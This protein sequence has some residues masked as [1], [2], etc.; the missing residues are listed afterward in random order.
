[1]K[2]DYYEIRNIYNNEINVN[3]KNK[4]RI[5]NFEKKKEMY[6]LR[7]YDELSKVTYNGGKYN[8]F[9]VYKPKIRVIMSQSVYDKTINHYV[10]RTILEPKLTKY[11]SDKNVATRKD[12]GT[13]RGILLLKKYIEE[14]KKYGKFYFLKLDIKKYFYNIDHEILKSLIVNDLDKD[15][16]KI[17]SNIIDSTNKPYINT[18]IK[19]LGNDLPEYKYGKGLP[20]GNLSSQFLAIF[21]LNRLHH[22][23]IHDLHIKHLIIYMDDYILIHPSKDYLKSVL[24]KI[25]YILNN[26]YKLELNK[27]KTYIK[28]S[29]EGIVFLG[30]HFKVINNKTIITLSN[31]AKRRIRNGI[32]TTKYKTVNNKICFKS[33]FSS[34]NTYKYSYKYQNSKYIENTLNKYWY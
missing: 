9:L 2:V 30:Y 34:I 11:L 23:I 12:M 28:S 6:F 16:Y 32:K 24:K 15:E 21:Y 22:Y 25:E 10:T 17:I 5:Y 33:A 20:I 29:H 19:K 13:K 31:D 14:N 26:E 4:K 3:V 8:L 1:M 18:T 7:M 27:N